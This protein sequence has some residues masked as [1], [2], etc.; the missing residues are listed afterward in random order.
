MLRHLQNNS[1]KSMMGFSYAP[2]RAA[3]PSGEAAQIVCH[4]K[5]VTVGQ[6]LLSCWESEWLAS[7]RHPIDALQPSFGL[8]FTCQLRQTVIP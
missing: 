7:C 3:S 5:T 6:A 2:I 1:Q 4:T 8:P